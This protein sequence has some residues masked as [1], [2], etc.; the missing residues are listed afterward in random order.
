M[1]HG[2]RALANNRKSWQI[3]QESTCLRAAKR[4]V[5]SVVI[6]EQGN[7]QSVIRDFINHSVLFVNSTRPITGNARNIDEPFSAL[8]SMT[9][10]PLPSR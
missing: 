4:N 9:E 3:A 1:G 2:K 10:A 8:E 7:K 6:P 5:K